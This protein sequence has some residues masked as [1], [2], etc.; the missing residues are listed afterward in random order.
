[1]PDQ[2]Q[3]TAKRPS[4][5]GRGGG[6]GSAGGRGG[7]GG[8]AGGGRGRGRG[9]RDGGEAKEFDQK[10]L[11][12]AR[13]TRVTKGGKRMRFRATIV[14]GD[15][16]GSVGVGV[17]KG[18]DVAMAVDKATRQARKKL[19]K[20]P[21]VDGTFPH[22]VLEKYAAAT[23]MLKP[24]PKGTGLKSGG[25]VRVLLELG[26]VPNAVSKIFGSTNK[27]NVARATMQALRELHV[28]E[29]PQA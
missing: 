29:K 9:D 6:G 28:P 24:A 13:V 19:F 10:I 16:K 12:L 27:I 21:L 5:R 8:R 7:G 11:E 4:F 20:I 22:A 15:H 2:T 25:A 1:M 14:I 3:K 23:V 18:A 17:A 26:G